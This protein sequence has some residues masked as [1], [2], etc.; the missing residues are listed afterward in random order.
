VQRL[1]GKVAVVTGAAS[2]IG[3]ATARRLWREGAEVGLADI[4]EQGARSLA[5]ELG[6]RALAI[7]FDAERPDTIKSAVE[8]AVSAFGRLD[9]LHNNA[10]LILPEIVAEDT[11]AVRID[12]DLWDRVMAVNVR[13]YLAGCK[14][15]IP[16][17]IDSGGGSIICTSSGLAL[18]GDLG[19]IA[20][21]TS[22]GAVNTLVKYVATQHGPQ[23]IRCNA[24]APGVVATPGVINTA[25]QFLKMVGRHLLTDPVTPEDIASIVAWLASDEARHVTG[26]VIGCDAGYRAHQPAY[27]DFRDAAPGSP[28]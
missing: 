8:Q 1:A 22:K 10:A 25:P 27:A 26:Q 3:A 14:Y 9:V 15:A 5:A 16:P 4:N 28:T 6:Q 24:V 11:D 13:G 20:Y 19:R 23:G 21:G 12:L 18:A 17:M 7:W 2:G